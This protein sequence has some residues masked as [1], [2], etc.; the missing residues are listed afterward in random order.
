[1]TLDAL[2]DRFLC[3]I[4]IEADKGGEAGTK[5][6]R[7][8]G[9]RERDVMEAEREIRKLA[10]TGPLLAGVPVSQDVI[11]RCV[12][13]YRMWCIL[14]QPSPLFFGVG[15]RVGCRGRHMCNSD[16]IRRGWSSLPPSHPLPRHARVVLATPLGQREGRTCDRLG[17]R[18]CCHPRS[19]Q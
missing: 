19:K 9:K 1:M 16:S 14:W 7:V 4:T 2:K 18:G 8:V 12:R 10:G 5:R 6:V 15:G 3:T 11:D 17:E 13:A